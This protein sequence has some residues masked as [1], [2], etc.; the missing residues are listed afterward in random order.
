[1]KCVG[2]NSKVVQQPVASV[3]PDRTVY[4]LMCDV[5]FVGGSHNTTACMAL[6]DIV[7]VRIQL[8]LACPTSLRAIW[9][10]DT[11]SKSHVAYPST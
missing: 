1:M 11:V 10:H 4:E 3:V 5:R 8:Q 2:Q 6:D 9:R 7:V